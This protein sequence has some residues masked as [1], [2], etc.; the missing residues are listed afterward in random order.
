M[1]SA[2]A[3]SCDPAIE[4]KSDGGLLIAEFN[5]R[6]DSPGPEGRR[7][8]VLARVVRRKAR[9]DVRRQAEVRAVGG[10]AA[11]QVDEA[12]LWHGGA[13]CK[14]AAS[15]TKK[16][17]RRTMSYS[18][19][20]G[21]QLPVIWSACATARFARSSGGHPSRALQESRKTVG[22]GS[23]THGS[24]SGAATEGS[25]SRRMAERVG[26]VDFVLRTFAADCF[27]SLTAAG[28]ALYGERAIASV[29]PGSLPVEASARA[30]SL[31]M[32]L[33]GAR[34]NLLRLQTIAPSNWCASPRELGRMRLTIHLNLNRSPD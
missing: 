24:P 26:F 6:H 32:S 23:R 12:L 3:K 2:C 7:R 20:Y 1:N 8:S 5:E 4:R 13:R 31:E 27:L 9:R 21:N 28:L 30:V 10:L 17:S 11:E 14:A 16:N 18:G 34:V 25:V 15:A 29:C 19:Y 22:L 33:V